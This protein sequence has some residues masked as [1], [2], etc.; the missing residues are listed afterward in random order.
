MI[1]L[2]LDTT[3]GLG[4]VWL[5]LLP[6]VGVALA[7]LV[8]FAIG[9]GQPVQTLAPREVTASGCWASLMSWYSFPYDIARADLTGDIVRASGAEERFPWNLAPLRALAILSTVGLGAP[10]GAESPAAH[11]GVAT[12]T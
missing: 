1:K 11:I 2:T 9:R 8:L 4:T 12:G 7:V 5:L 10:M 6:L 3:S